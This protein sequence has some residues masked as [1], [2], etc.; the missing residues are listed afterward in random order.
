MDRKPSLAPAST[1]TKDA[2]HGVSLEEALSICG[3]GRYQRFIALVGGLCWL[4]CALQ[5]SLS[6]YILPSI[7]CEM[8]VS[9]S[10]LGLFNAVFLAGGLSSSILWGVLID[11]IGRR[12]VLVY[13]MALDSFLTIVSSFSQNF[14][15]LLVARF[16][17]GF[18]VGGPAAISPAFVGEFQPGH[19]RQQIICYIGFFWTVSWVILPGAAWLIIPMNIH[20]HWSGYSYSSWRFIM[21]LV[22]I[23]SLISSILIYRY[24]ESPRFLLAQGRA[25]ETLDVLSEIWEVNTGRKAETYPVKSLDYVSN[26]SVIKEEPKSI[27]RPL[28]IMLTQWQSLLAMPVL[29]ITLLG[30]F[31]FFSNMFGYYGL[32]LWL[33]ELVNRFEAHYAVSNQTVRLCDLTSKI[34]TAEKNNEDCVVPSTVFVQSLIIGS[35]GLVG[36][37]LSGLLSS[38]FPR[39]V[40]PVI[41]T[42]AAGASVL[43]LYFV[44]SSFQNLLVSTIFQFCIGTCNMVL[45]SLIVDMFPA[46]ISGIAICMCVMSGRLGAM[47]SNLVLGHL[48]DVSCVIPILLCAGV[49][50]LGAVFSAFIPKVPYSEKIKKQEKNVI[51]A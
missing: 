9:S 48:L 19:K 2:L 5:N 16:L 18:I 47:L 1:A 8:H 23:S 28:K 27:W 49:I 32:G 12:P 14:Y 13:G 26:T 38:K 37:G 43:T 21:V 51:K 22:S 42:S 44:Q 24:P 45:N 30:C 15:L 50:I 3:Y 11:S 41:L 46:D 33:P 4:S 29:P 20:L 7:K 34:E 31:L 17:S 36:N 6:A 10:M 35:M 39:P 40:M 25:P